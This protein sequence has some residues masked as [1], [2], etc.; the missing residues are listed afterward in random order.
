[1]IAKYEGYGWDLHIQSG[2]DSL[3]KSLFNID[4]EVMRHLPS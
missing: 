4:I 3:I 1:M 2:K